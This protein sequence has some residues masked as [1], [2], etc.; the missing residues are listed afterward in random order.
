MPG[1]IRP[2]LTL[3]LPLAAVLVAGCA[4]FSDNDAVARFDE[5]ELGADE[6]V[7]LMSAIRP[8]NVEG[9]PTDAN[10]ARDVISTWVRIEAV[11]QKLDDD[12][13]AVTDA[14]LD[15]ATTQMSS[16]VPDFT[17][18]PDRTR[19]YLV[20]AQAAFLAFANVEPPSEAAIRELYQLGPERG[21]VTCVAH[22]LVET[23][24]E[25]D[26]VAAELAAGAEFAALA[27]ERSL[28]PGSAAQGGIIPCAATEEFAGTYVR[29]FV[30]AALAAEIGVPTA[31]VESDFGYH[32][33]RVRP[34]DEAQAELAAF[35]QPQ[36][37]L[38][39]RAIEQADI[40]VDPRYGTIDRG[41]VVPL[42]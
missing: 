27:V 30:E 31:P 10:A 42:S 7:D 16:L 21:G 6:L 37:F 4:S 25:A 23:E 26:A 12:G 11:K 5:V 34:F 9:D 3:L 2:R 1:V 32:V 40:Y 39:A 19:D 8:P 24:A 41:R 28:D 17:E 14:Q 29:P 15:E 33:I 35:V 22:I 13:V 38:I 18:L 36:E 20:G